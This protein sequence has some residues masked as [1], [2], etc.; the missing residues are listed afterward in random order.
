MKERP[1]LKECRICAHRVAGLV[2][3]GSLFL[4]L[5]KLSVGIFAHSASVAADGL[6]SSAIAISAGLVMVGLK[7]GRKP[8]DH[9]FPYG[10]GRVELLVA[11][12][13]YAALFGLGLFL[14]VGSVCLVVSGRFTGP[15]LIALPVSAIS[16]VGTYLMYSVCRCAGKATGSSGLMADAQQNLA[17]T[18]TSAAVLI[19]VS[20]AQ[21]G[22]AF[23]WCDSVGAGVV[24]LLIMKDAAKSWWTDL[25]VLLDT[26]LPRSQTSQISTAA[27]AVRGV[28][29]SRFVK[30][31]R[32]GQRVW[33]DVGV[34][35][36]PACTVSE[37]ER[38]S[39]DT[40]ESVLRRLAWVEDIEVF[41]YPAYAGILDEWTDEVRHDLRASPS[42]DVDLGMGI[43]RRTRV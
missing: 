28:T 26:S 21:L 17:D 27:L 31:R 8:A 42:G 39:T 34:L 13:A 20:L 15:T 19:S 3:A 7:F 22:P 43:R 41:V 12:I 25:C 35:V 14:T 24:G 38:I 4:G 1:T 40:R 18:L 23:H 33:A 2:V 36:A 32:T 16:I 29:Q 30:T 10:Y 11:V 6:E 9:K 5:L 37:A